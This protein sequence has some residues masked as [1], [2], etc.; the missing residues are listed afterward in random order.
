MSS[1]INNQPVTIQRLIIPEGT[2]LH[3]NTNASLPPLEGSIAF[4]RS[5][6]AGTIYSGTGLSWLAAAQG[7][8]VV[9]PS[10]SN[11]NDLVA[12]DGLTGKL[13]KDSAIP[14]ADVVTASTTSVSG[15]LVAYNGNGGRVIQDSGVAIT[16]TSFSV[17]L[18][19]VAGN[20]NITADVKMQRIGSM[21]QYYVSNFNLTGVL[22]AATPDSWVQAGAIPSGY[23]PS[24]VIAVN[25][26]VY[27]FDQLGNQITNGQLVFTKSNG[28]LT[29]IISGVNN[30]GD[31]PSPFDVCGNYPV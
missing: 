18:V 22:T 12:F 6:V 17:T 26:S 19:S 31:Q 11:N 23:R 30:I 5:G 7:G 28:N 16:S 1:Q 24:P 29:L 14:S 4:D 8:D 15:N 2:G 21:V 27:Y 13:L 9:G 3:N 25:P 20:P 10:V